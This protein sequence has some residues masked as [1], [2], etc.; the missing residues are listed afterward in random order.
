MRALLINTSGGEGVVALADEAGVIAEEMLPGR[1]TSEALMPAVRRLFPEGFEGLGVVG[2]VIGPGSFTGVRVGLSA[3][4]GLCEALGVGMVAMSRLELVAGAAGGERVVALLDGGRGEFYCGVYEGGERVSEELVTEVE[5]RMVMASGV[6]VTCEAQVAERLGVRMVGEPGAA[7][8]LATVLRR[9]AAGEWSDV[10][11]V[12]A[13][14]LRR[15]DA[16]LL[17]KA[18]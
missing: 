4:K 9:V 5:A 10:A 16:E 18:K 3:A 11:T 12:D 17:V 8:M 6:A 14:Y 2:V 15:T 7:A 1:G 13:N